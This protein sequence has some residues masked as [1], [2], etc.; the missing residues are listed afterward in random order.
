[1]MLFISIGIAVSIIGMMTYAVVIGKS[2][3]NKE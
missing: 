2:H 1:M 3:G